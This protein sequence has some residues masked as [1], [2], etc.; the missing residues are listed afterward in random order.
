MELN[1]KNSLKKAQMP[2]QQRA[3]NR[4]LLKEL[5]LMREEEF[6]S[7]TPQT[8]F[9]Q[10]GRSELQKSLKLKPCGYQQGR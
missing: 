10:S 7:E 6:T 2:V 3:K 8:S 1:L 4:R 9:F 5:K